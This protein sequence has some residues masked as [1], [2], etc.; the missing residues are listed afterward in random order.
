METFYGITTGQAL[1]SGLRQHDA[2]AGFRDVFVNLA[3]GYK[4]SEHWTLIVQA[5]YR[6]LVGDAAD[7][8]IVDDEGSPNSLVGGLGLSYTF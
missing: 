3:S 7:S 6:R 2:D 4:F 5:Q 1:R 8:P